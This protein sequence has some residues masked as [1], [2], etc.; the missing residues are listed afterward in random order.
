[1]IKTQN[2]AYKKLLKI[3]EKLSHYES[4]LS[5]LFW[6]DRVCMPSQAAPYRG[7]QI[8]L[9]TEYTH[10]IKTSKAYGKLIESLNHEEY[11]P[12]SPEWVNIKWWKY[13]YERNK[14]IP[15]KLISKLSELIPS[16]LQAWE[17]AKKEKKFKI[18]QPYLKKIIEINKEMIEKWGYQKEP[19]EALVQNYEIDITPQEIENI[20]IPLK[21]NL[22][23]LISKYHNESNN[24][25]LTKISFE[26]TK[27]EQFCKLMIKEISNLDIRLDPTSHPFATTISPYDIRITTRYNN[28]ESAIFGTLHELGHGLYDY[29]LPYDKYFGQPKA[30]SVSLSVHESQSRFFE[31]II[32]RSYGF[33]KYFYPVL[34]Q[35]IEPLKNIRLEDFVK[36][37]NKIKLQPIRTEADET[38]YNLH[39]IL[40]FYIERKIF[41]ENLKI[42]ELPEIWNETFK[43]YFGYRPKDDSEGVL[44]D[45]HWAES[46][47]G[48][49]PTYTLGN[50][51][52]S[53]IYNTISQKINIKEINTQTFK[54][55]IEFLKENVYLY[56]KTYSTQELVEKITEEKI[57]PKYFLEYLENKLQNVYNL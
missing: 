56:G 27:L 42:Q 31:N 49:F 46:L 5:L 40:R 14:K 28:L 21:T 29:Y 57:N 26:K 52:S 8:A 37:V 15:T 45:I 23:K 25:D 38:T 4:I 35:Y 50:L 1:M 13:Q 19:Y 17:K 3:H 53:Q 32:G 54:E 20:F 18:L 41:N 51:I 30:E 16:S 24:L 34:T 43:E 6:D 7:K 44:Q 47:F 2:S 55:I 36:S 48:Y 11:E 33:W 12:Y 22:K 10:K 9:I 39:I